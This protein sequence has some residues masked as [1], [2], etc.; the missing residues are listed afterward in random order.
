MFRA[1][2]AA[3]AALFAVCLM[4]CCVE[5]AEAGK[6]RDRHHK[7]QTCDCA[8][9]AATCGADCPG[10]ACKVPNKA[11]ETIEP[12][13]H[14]EPKKKVSLQQS[15]DALDEVNAERARRGL[16]AF[17]R[18]PLLTKAAYDCARYRCETRTEGHTTGGSGDFAYLPSGAVATAAGCG[19]L[20]PSWGW[21]TCC[22]YDNYTY[23]GAAWVMGQDGRRYMQLFVR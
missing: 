3:G 4:V 11:N 22:T 2:K 7:A 8:N 18:D 16:R 1:W 14:T 23:A 15:E 19:A 13:Q 21:G 10:G 17:I 5:T 12:K 20:E 9:C 6:H